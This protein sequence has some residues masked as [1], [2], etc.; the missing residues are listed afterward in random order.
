MVGRVSLTALESNM[1]VVAKQQ[2]QDS[3]KEGASRDCG[4]TKIRSSEASG[5]GPTSALEQNMGPSTNAAF[6]WGQIPTSQCSVKG[7][8]ENKLIYSSKSTKSA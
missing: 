3:F 6:A 8:F 7:A 2:A 5:Y 4:G 1:V